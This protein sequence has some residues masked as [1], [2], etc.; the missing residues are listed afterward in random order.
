[1]D[2]YSRKY[3]MVPKNQFGVSLFPLRISEV[4]AWFSER[5]DVEML[6]E[7][8]RYLP[9]WTRWIVRVPGAREIVTWNLALVFR[10]VGP[11]S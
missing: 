7:G 6:W 1:M 8:S 9:D 2:R 5:T 10:R 4:R 11:T 3:G